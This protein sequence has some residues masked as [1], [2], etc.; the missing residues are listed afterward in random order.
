ML[1]IE[2][3]AHIHLDFLSRYSS[4]Y[5]FRVVLLNANLLRV[6]VIVNL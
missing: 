2:S 3:N 1:I 6:T 5:R 4:Q